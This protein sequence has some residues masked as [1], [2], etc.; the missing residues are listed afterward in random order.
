MSDQGF[1]ITADRDWWGSVPKVD[2]PFP[3]HRRGIRDGVR[4]PEAHFAT[5]DNELCRGCVPRSA[6]HETMTCSVCLSKFKDALGRLAFLISH[7]R[8][9]ERSGDALGERVDTSMTR[10][11]LVPDS[12]IAADD[13]MTALGAQ[14]FKSTDTIDVAIG[15]AHDVVADW[16]ANFDQRINTAEGASQ[17][18]VTVKRMQ[19]ALHRWPDAEAER[20]PVKYLICPGGCGQKNLYRKA[21][22]EYLDDIDVV[23]ATDG[24][25]WRMDWFD[26]SRVYAPVL[27][28]MLR[29]EQQAE[30]ERRKAKKEAS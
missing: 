13:L 21:P 28:G 6:V 18:V 26:F 2:R 24:C 17:A 8:S 11:I 14:P 15:K 22:L 1:C 19:N 12:W 4:V 27:E 25:G 7:L 29:E 16:W 30:R 20:R 9:V 3:C 23:C 10:S 5:C